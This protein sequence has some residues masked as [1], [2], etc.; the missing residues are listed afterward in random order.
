M[1]LVIKY[2]L[3]IPDL[4]GWMMVVKAACLPRSA[5]FSMSGD[6]GKGKGWLMKR[7]MLCRT[8][9]CRLVLAQA[10]PHHITPSVA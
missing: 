5:R 7:T 1:K 4:I 8:A 2:D 6:G 3:A 9:A 10:P